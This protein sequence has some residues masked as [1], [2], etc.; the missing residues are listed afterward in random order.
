MENNQI[1]LQLGLY[2]PSFP[3]A[4]GP[5]MLNQGGHQSSGDLSIP[6]IQRSWVRIPITPSMVL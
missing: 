2:E 3:Y 4:K 1:C 5:K 6:T